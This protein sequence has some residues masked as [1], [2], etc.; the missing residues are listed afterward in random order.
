MC[1]CSSGE[2]AQPRR[3]V[4]S[5]RLCVGAFW[6]RA[7]T[8]DERPINLVVC[9]FDDDCYIDQQIENKNIRYTGCCCKDKPAYAYM[10]SQS[11]GATRRGVGGEIMPRPATN[12]SIS[13]A[14]LLPLEL[15]AQSA[16]CSLSRSG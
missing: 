7:I 10:Q 6:Q 1:V 3:M 14:A 8:S 2:H 11:S 15:L 12:Q 4:L 5:V 9:L 13:G 16:D